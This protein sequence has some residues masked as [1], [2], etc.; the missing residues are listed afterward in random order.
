M[1][2][3]MK[4]IK[5]SGDEN[6]I[7]YAKS[8]ARYFGIFHNMGYIVNPT[9]ISLEEDKYGMNYL[10]NY[11]ESFVDTAKMSIVGVIE[12]LANDEPVDPFCKY[13]MFT[14]MYTPQQV[15]EIEHEEIYR[16]KKE[17]EKQEGLDNGSIVK[18]YYVSSAYG[19]ID[20]V[21][22]FITVY[23]LNDGYGDDEYEEK[24]KIPIPINF[25]KDWFREFEEINRVQFPR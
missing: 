2:E 6:N 9:E 23:T 25:T 13:L 20:E 8:L 1:C 5:E 10:C 22:S 14:H 24:L 7:R 17:I 15:K 21:R 16:R 3:S 18:K 4:K 11:L 19:M 12:A